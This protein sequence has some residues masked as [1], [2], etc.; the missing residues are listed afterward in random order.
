MTSSAPEVVVRGMASGGDGVATL[1]DGRTVFVPRAAPGDRLRLRGVRLHARFARAEVGEVIESGPDRV[2]PPCPHYTG[3]RCGG[4]QVM[5]LSA[6][7]QRAAKARAAGDA[8]R[9]LAKL[10][11]ED[12]DVAPAPSQF[13]YRSKVTLAVRGDRVGYRRI[14]DPDNVFDVRT[15]L[16][17][18]PDVQRLIDAFRR[19][20]R[21][22]PKHATRVVLRRDRDDRLHVVVRT[23]P[24]S[25]WTDGAALHRS[26]TQG[27]VQ[28]TVWWHPEGGA[29]RAVAGSDN[30][31]PVT[32]FEQ[33]HP[34]MGQLVR[35]SALD[36]LGD[37]RGQH[38]WDLYAGIGET[39]V[40]LVERG[41]T[42]ESI[43][44]DGRA[45]AQAEQLGPVGPVR[46]AGAAEELAAHLRAPAAIVTNPPR[47][48]MDAEVARVIAASGA[49]RLA[50]ISCDAATLARDI[51]RL[52][53]AY[54]VRQV[55]GFDQFPQTAHL[56]CVALLE[57]R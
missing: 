57:R 6:P 30:P 48:G 23:D 42:V 52:A 11:I 29:P 18:E 35:Q 7:A 44:R 9:R 47:T 13:G 43:E 15:C 34:A 41:A 50:Y 37:V 2:D 33:V 4:C 53:A 26:L 3:D 54:T 31:W 10:D 39:T 8:L 27:G 20:R 17:A 22:L 55:K 5:H 49:S 14:H 1:P 56:E 45:V 46:H 32:V 28:A 24:G 16:V 38:A 51:A 12:P 40:A 36:A 25:A 21:H 19:A